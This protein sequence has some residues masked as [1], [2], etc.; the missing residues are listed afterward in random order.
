M[1]AE[2]QTQKGEEKQIKQYNIT[3]RS[4]AVARIANRRERWGKMT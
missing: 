3:T 1:K 2:T 4:Q